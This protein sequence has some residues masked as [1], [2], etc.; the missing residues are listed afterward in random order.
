MFTS[1][2]VSITISILKAEGMQVLA[3]HS[4]NKYHAGFG[5]AFHR[6]KACRF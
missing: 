5:Y 4:I 2:L 1:L 3:T 6:Q